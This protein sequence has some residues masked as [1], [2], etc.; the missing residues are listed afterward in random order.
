MMCVFQIISTNVSKE[1]EVI[2]LPTA[3]TYITGAA[4]WDVLVRRAQLKIYVTLLLHAKP[5]HILAARKAFRH[6][7]I[8]NPWGEVQAICRINK[9]LLLQKL[10]WIIYERFGRIFL[11]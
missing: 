6:S 4:H 5:V 7:M 10:I 9:V 2:I 3:F 1:V 8:V 11:Y